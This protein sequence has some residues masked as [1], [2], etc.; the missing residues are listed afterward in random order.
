MMQK[1]QIIVIPQNLL[2]EQSKNFLKQRQMLPNTFLNKP[3]AAVAGHKRP[4]PSL[5]P[6]LKPIL[7]RPISP[8]KPA[9]VKLDLDMELKTEDIEDDLNQQPARKRANLDHL[10]PEERL[11]RRKLKNRVA[12]Q[13]ARDKKKAYIDEMEA[14]LQKMRD[15]NKRIQLENS[16]LQ[17]ANSSLQVQN[18]SLLQRNKELEARLGQSSTSATTTTDLYT[19]PA[20]PESL[21]SRS[22]SP[23]ADCVIRSSASPSAALT[24]PEPAVLDVPLPQETD[25]REHRTVDPG[26]SSNDLTTWLTNCAPQMLMLWV[27]ILF[28][29]KNKNSN[30]SVLLMPTNFSTWEESTSLKIQPLTDQGMRLPPK[31][32]CSW[33]ERGSPPAPPVPPA[34]D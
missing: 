22:P 5:S 3:I 33:T 8:Y 1:P 10:S 4:A 30:K 32:R 11:M 16:R 26:L 27:I 19:L 2:S 23:P 13:T 15:E 34:L 9:T 29:N 21:P 7:K 12:A 17:D 18:A 20:S 24:S 31:K 28:L 25:V 14:V 6:E